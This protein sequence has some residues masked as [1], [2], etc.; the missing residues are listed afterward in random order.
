MSANIQ[1]VVVTPTEAQAKAIRILARSSSKQSASELA[2]N[3]FAQVVRGRF[4]AKKET[5]ADEAT[6]K[7]NTAASIMGT[8]KMPM[9]LKEYVA[10]YVEEFNEVLLE[11]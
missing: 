1:A 5:A 4:K 10:K 11:L 9:P 2:E 8:D 3:L 6:E 7:W